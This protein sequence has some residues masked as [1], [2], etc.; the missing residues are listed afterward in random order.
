[1]GK[2]K[3]RF[4]GVLLAF[5]GAQI[6]LIALYWGLDAG[7]GMTSSAGIL[8]LFIIQQAFVFFRIQLR[9]MMYAGLYY[10]AAPSMEE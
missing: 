4:L 9:Q 2:S 5:G 1:M 6:V 10:L 3:G 7:I 8:I